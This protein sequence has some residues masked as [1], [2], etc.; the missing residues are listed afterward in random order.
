MSKLFKL[1]TNEAITFHPEENGL[2]IFLNKEPLHFFSSDEIL[3]L[4]DAKL[5][6]IVLSSLKNKNSI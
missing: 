6:E 4:K 1:I 3:D 2:H 5:T